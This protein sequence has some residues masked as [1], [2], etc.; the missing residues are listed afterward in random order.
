MAFSIAARLRRQI[1]TGVRD[2]IDRRLPDGERTKCQAALLYYSDHDD[3][4][5]GRPYIKAGRQAAVEYAGISSHWARQEDRILTSSRGAFS[6]SS[7]SS[8]WNEP[9]VASDQPQPV[10]G[11]QTISTISRGD[12]YGV[13]SLLFLNVIVAWEGIRTWR[14]ID[15][16]D[17]LTFFLARFTFFGEHLRNFDLPGW[18]PYTLSGAPYLGD[19]ESGWFYLPA[20]VSFTI[21]PGT[22]GY[23]ALIIFHFL[24]AGLATYAFARVLGMNVAGAAVAGAAYEFTALGEH[25]HCCFVFAA[26]E[27]WIPVALLGIELAT[28]ARTWLFR[29]GWWTVAGFAISQMLGV[30]LGQGAYYGLLA[31]GAYAVHRTLIWPPNREASVLDRFVSAAVHGT[32]ILAIG[33]GLAAG[34]ILPRLAV[35][36]QAYLDGDYSSVNGFSRGWVN[37]RAPIDYLLTMDN[38]EGRWY[39]GGAVFALAVLALMLARFRYA[40]PFFLVYSL[41]VLSLTQQ[42]VNSRSVLHVLPGFMDLHRHLPERVMIIFYFGP[43]MLAGATVSALAEPIAGR[44]S[45]V[46][47]WSSAVLAM[48][49]FASLLW[50][51]D[52]FDGRGEP[53][54]PVTLFAVGIVGTLIAL[55]VI[56]PKAIVLRVVSVVVLLTV[57]ADPTGHRIGDR[58]PSFQPD[59]ESDEI[60]T[61]FTEP[62]TVGQFLQEQQASS[63]DPF[64]FFGYDPAQLFFNG[65]TNNYLI[66]RWSPLTLALHVNNKAVSLGLEDIQGYN[67]IQSERYVDFINAINNGE[68]QGYHQSNILYRGVTSP[69]INLLNVRYIIVPATIPPGRPDLFHVSQRHR[70]VYA[71]ETVRILE[72]EDA[73]PRAWIVHRAGRYQANHG[74]EMI[75]SGEA[76]PREIALLDRNVER[77]VLELPADSTEESVQLVDYQPDR[78]TLQATTTAA[79]LVVL[80]EVYDPGWKAY[81]D[82]EQ[83]PVYAA[84]TALR[85]V[86]V[87]EGT[88]TIELRYETPGLNLGLLITGA[89]VA[90]V[91]IVL[92]YL[93]FRRRSGRPLMVG[94]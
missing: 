77:P 4:N 80:S 62:D 6:H 37:L 43:A 53:L 68:K 30:W 13:L 29:V 73:F 57:F 74:L 40:T 18:I 42:E 54:E 64:R 93:L 70:T 89:T 55:A 47:R 5:R 17:I 3:N 2:E 76:D 38:S 75:A 92:G 51:Y 79:G 1:V 35:V 28:R 16:T 14:M 41:V 88:H 65:R 58:L 21:A 24:V 15:S 12:L 67:P 56:I 86:P 71:D 63:E 49:P 20:M 46:W 91:G 19:P 78:L 25:T 22:T 27:T 11:K 9:L 81:V 61:S 50:F 26:V 31:V 59:A 72:N 39:M 45:S 34:G 7:I 69:L 8:P 82:G 90:I 85:A 83:V 48:V 84:Y 36:S 44:W 66:T 52:F 60:V 87:P 23:F 10:V 94:R 32:A 33:F